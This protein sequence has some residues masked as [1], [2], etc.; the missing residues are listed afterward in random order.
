MIGVKVILVDDSSS[1]HVPDLEVTDNILAHDIVLGC[2]F[3]TLGMQVGYAE[4]DNVTL[5]VWRDMLC[6]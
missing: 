1:K 4:G 3:K 2:C 6:L 5:V